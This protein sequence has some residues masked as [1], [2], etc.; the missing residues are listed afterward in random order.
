MHRGIV[1]CV[2]SIIFFALSLRLRERPE[3][4]LS[5]LALF[6]SHFKWLF[7]VVPPGSGINSQCIMAVNK[8]FLLAAASS[9][10]SMLISICQGRLFSCSSSCIALFNE[11][12]E[13]ETERREQCTGYVIT[14]CDCC[15]GQRLQC[16]THTQSHRQTYRHTHAHTHT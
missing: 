7:V 8:L 4:E 13:T 11:I 2:C 14:Y 12:N 6:L 10:H 5:P 15:P 16:S 3:T 9:R 1:H